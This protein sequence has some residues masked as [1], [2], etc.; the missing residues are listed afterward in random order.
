AF[1]ARPSFEAPI[2]SLEDLLKATKQGYIPI[3]LAGT[4]N[5]FLFKGASAG[6][7]KKIWESRHPS[8]SVTHT[9]D[10]AMDVV[11]KGKRVFVNARLG[12]VI[13]AA[14]RGSHKYHLARQAMYP[15]NYGI[16]CSSGAPYNNLFT[17][18]L[19]RMVETGLVDK[20][21]QDQ[22][23][24]VT[25]THGNGGDDGDSGRGGD[26]TTLMGPDAISLTHLQGA[27]F[28]LGFG[29]LVAVLA[30][31]GEAYVHCSCLQAAP[32]IHISL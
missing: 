7:F 32:Q 30:L 23:N 2:D 17:D 24:K 18:L 14:V 12:A 13:R 6:I 11:L 31:L 21:T 8:Q 26:K 25:K 10:Q 29:Y 5:E 16:A 19:L 9:I 4:S 15:Q 20:W 1:L 27:F 3:F 22:V 28:I